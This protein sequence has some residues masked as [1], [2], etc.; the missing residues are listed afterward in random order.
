MQS[1]TVSNPSRFITSRNSTEDIGFFN[2]KQGSD[3]IDI[4]FLRAI[5]ECM[6]RFQ[7]TT[8]IQSIPST[9]NEFH[10]HWL[11]SLAER[12][13]ES[14]SLIQHIFTKYTIQADPVL[15]HYYQSKLERITKSQE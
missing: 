1:G 13:S 9:L 5:K 15:L 7:S 8:I 14:T 4:L 10:L 12:K 2:S 6:L 3:D 11:C